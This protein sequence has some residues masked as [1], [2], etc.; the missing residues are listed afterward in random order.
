MLRAM[1]RL[2]DVSSFT[3]IYKNLRSISGMAITTDVIV[4]FPGETEEMFRNTMSLMESLRFD[5]AFMFAYSPRSGT[6]AAALPQIPFE[7]KR[8]RLRE[9][10]EMQNSITCELNSADVGK[11]FEVLVEG[12]SQKDPRFLKGL[13]RHFKTMH[14]PGTCKPGEIVE[15]AA[16][17][18]HLWG[19]SGC[20]A[21]RRCRSDRPLRG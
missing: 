21:N 6:P 5:S 1:K 8:R 16:E 3:D 7:I 17:N 13:T 4:G 9:L 20:L 11:N 19:L 10:I 12:P 14:F 18:A 15:V 2:Y